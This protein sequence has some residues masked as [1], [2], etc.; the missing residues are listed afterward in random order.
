MIPIELTGQANITDQ[1]DEA[2]YRPDDRFDNV[3]PSQSK[4]REFFFSQN[5]DN[6]NAQSGDAKL[7]SRIQQKSWN[8]GNAAVCNKI[9]QLISQCGIQKKNSQS[10][11]SNNPKINI[12]SFLLCRKLLFPH[13]C[14]FALLKLRIY[15]MN[16][17]TPK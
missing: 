6:G 17:S 7:D 5:A 4:L 3:F 10:N 8:N 1:R 2:Y 13:I 15:R 11:Q 12:Q 14:T 9:V 16:Y